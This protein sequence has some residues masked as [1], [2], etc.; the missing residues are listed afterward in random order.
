VTSARHVLLAWTFPP[1]SVVGVAILAVAYLE[2][3]RVV[4]RGGGLPNPKK[5]TACFL[6]GV[7]VLALSLLSPIDTYAEQLLSVHMVQHLLITMVAAPLLLLGGPV[8]LILRSA[9]PLGRRRFLRPALRSGVAR[10]LGNPVVAWTGFAVIMWGTHFTGL[11]ELA[12]ERQ[13]VHA[14][15][16]LVYL[17]AA[18]LFWWPVLG[19]DPSPSRLPHAAR[20]L[21]LFAAMPVTAFLG[22]AIYGS[23][24]VLYPHYL[25]ASARLGVSALND[26]HL[27]GAIMWVSAMVVM[28]PALGKVLFDWLDREDREGARMMAGPVGAA[29]GSPQA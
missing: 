5:R 1:A 6:A 29:E 24:R 18:L 17:A 2:G 15:E 9:T 11:Y 10:T 27:A 26:Q 22:L 28:L 4:S 3:V 23:D 20:I 12:L 25:V 7:G 19:V 21:Y 14:L 13:S 16:H 8:T